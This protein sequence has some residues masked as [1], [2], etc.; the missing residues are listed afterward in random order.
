MDLMK[1]V[2]RKKDLLETDLTGKE[3]MN[4]DMIEIKN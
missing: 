3:L 1:M 4:M 2:L